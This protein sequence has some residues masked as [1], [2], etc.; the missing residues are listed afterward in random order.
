MPST[1]IQKFEI[2]MN[3]EQMSQSGADYN[4]IQEQLSSKNQ[5]QNLDIVQ[6]MDA[7]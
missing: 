2:N 7:S 5:T 3:L 1:L 4:F 6:L